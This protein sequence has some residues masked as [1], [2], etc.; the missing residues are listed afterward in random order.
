MEMIHEQDGVYIEAKDILIGSEA[1]FGKN[2]D[3]RCKGT[4]QIGDRS[5]L[6]SNVRIRGRNVSFGNDLWHTDGLDVGGGSCDHP[7]SHLLVG[8][9]C[10]MHNCHINIARNVVIGDDVGLSPDVVILAHGF[11][12]S[13]LDGFPAKF[14]GVSIGSGAIIGRGAIILPGVHIGVE[15]IIGAGSVVTK[16]TEPRS[17]SA[18]NP[19]RCIRNITTP[20]REEVIQKMS[21]ILREYDAVAEYHGASVDV[22]Y[23]HPVVRANNFWFNLTTMQYGGEEDDDVAD[24][25]D[26]L[27]RYGIRLYTGRPFRSKLTW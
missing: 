15:S 22:R 13:V 19:C 7:D 3:I 5:H 2:V 25:R 24:F 21:E 10:T 8:H 23:D 26:F 11:W 27:R 18:G 6:G 17:V 20:S 16:N 1:S 9:R 12:L 4:F 14:A